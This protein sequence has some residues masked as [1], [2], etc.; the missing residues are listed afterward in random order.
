MTHVMR[1]PVQMVALV[2]LERIMLRNVTAHLDTPENIAKQESIFIFL[3]RLLVFLAK[4]VLLHRIF[5][6]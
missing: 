2:Q 5:F 3:L 6:A 4:N 1:I